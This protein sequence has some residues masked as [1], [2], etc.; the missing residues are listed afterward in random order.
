MTTTDP[1]QGEFPA[2]P[3]PPGKQQGEMVW[4]ETEWSEPLLASRPTVLALPP[5]PCYPQ[6][7]CETQMLNGTSWNS[8]GWGR[9]S[10]PGLCSPS[11]E[12]RQAKKQASR[13]TGS[14][15][16]SALLPNFYQMLGTP[17]TCSAR[18]PNL[19]PVILMWLWLSGCSPS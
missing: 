19:Y 5:V 17:Q 7:T 9:C 10:G 13:S 1:G 8:P 15:P 14:L 2:A 12:H 11:D 3:G 6:P 18:L 16:I 4:P